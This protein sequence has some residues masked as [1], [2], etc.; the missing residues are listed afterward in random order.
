MLIRKL[1]LTQFPLI[2]L[3]WI[4][5]ASVSLLMPS[6]SSVVEAI[7]NP[8]R[9]NAPQNLVDKAMVIPSSGNSQQCNGEGYTGCSV[10]TISKGDRVFFAGNDDYINPDSYYWVDPGGGKRYGVI[11]VGTRDNVQQGVNE[12]GLAY[13]ANGLPWIDVNPHLERP[14]VIGDYTIYPVKIMHECATVE[15]VID[16]VN[17]HRWHSYMHDQMQFADATGDAVI[18]S[19]G[20]D[21]EVAFTRKPEG[22]S[23]L[24]STNFNVANPSNGYGYPCPR[25]ETATENL[26]SLLDQEDE[27]T[28]QDAANV[29]DA[30]HEEGA[31][32]W[33]IESMV[34]DLPNGIVYL[35]YFH[36][37][38]KP[39]VLNVAE[40]LANLRTGVPLSKLF[41]EDVQ[42]EARR[43][44]Q[45]ILTRRDHNQ[46]I[47]KVWLGLVLAS[48]VV[49]LV[50]LWLTR[51]G[52]FFWIS[53]VLILG[54][55]GLL[56]WFVTGRKQTSNIWK[57]ALLEATGDIVPSV[58]AFMLF[59]SLGIRST[60]VQSSQGIQILL[61]IGLPLV[62]GWGVFRVPLL[63]I[64]KQSGKIISVIRQLL[65]SW[66]VA[67]LGMAGIF[68]LALPL[69]NKSLQMETPRWTVFAWW[70]YVVLGSVIALL[71]LMLYE[72]W[73]VH[74]GYK[75]WTV[76]AWG[77]GQ[78]SLISWKRLWWWV[79]ISPIVFIGGIVAYQYIQ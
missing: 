33:T 48:L 32:S 69:V 18:I 35:Y 19:A 2:F 45:A 79:L 11:W 28:F 36:Q 10:F 66:V 71:L 43:R 77:E 37:F 65:H 7:P 57:R 51:R 44:Y 60:T 17:T 78:P 3:A 73:Q 53:V 59:I 70:S 39:V 75:F 50:G 12:K 31:A 67:N 54:P 5:S 40:E 58:I 61:I 62:L 25:Y 23:Y 15:E 4:L 30:V 9:P 64:S 24:V 29:L 56:M 68:A 27:L 47:G 22:D 41:P 14:A 72:T 26:E 8:E 52:W 20:I 13:D 46:V 38:D 16:W 34:A 6:S 49:L 21:G 55:L 42:Q 1:D 76:F 74:R 63:L